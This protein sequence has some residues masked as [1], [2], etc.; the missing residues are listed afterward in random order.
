M[1]EVNVRCS[2]KYRDG[3][4]VGFWIFRTYDLDRILLKICHNR[5][6][7]RKNHNFETGELLYKI[8]GTPVVSWRHRGRV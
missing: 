8:D 5:S 2:L 3:K 7:S 4:K 1:A 6:W